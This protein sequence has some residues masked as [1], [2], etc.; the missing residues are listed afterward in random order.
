MINTCITRLYNYDL[1]LYSCLR[2]I[3]SVFSTLVSIEALNSYLESDSTL[4]VLHET[5]LKFCS[6][7]YDL[8]V[9]GTCAGLKLQFLIHEYAAIDPTLT[10]LYIADNCLLVDSGHMLCTN[11]YSVDKACVFMP[12][13]CPNLC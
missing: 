10:P 9:R 13:K 12:M 1:K 4:T 7:L 3:R 2:H 5:V 11:M 6:L 8:I